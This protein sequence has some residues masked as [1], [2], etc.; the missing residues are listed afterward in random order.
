[1]IL[2]DTNVVIAVLK[3][4]S[5]AVRKRLSAAVVG[6]TQVCISSIVV[7][8]L[9]FGAGRSAREKYNKD[10]LADFLSGDIETLQF[11]EEDA[12]F[13]GSMRAKLVNIGNPIGPYDILIAGQAL[14]HDA[15]LVTANTREF[16]RVPGL[17]VEDWAK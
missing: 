15:T 16:A 9:A 7:F 1:M 17:K 11:D 4:N 8:E 6:G 14:R 2:L 13:A 3:R 10:R 12:L 5:I